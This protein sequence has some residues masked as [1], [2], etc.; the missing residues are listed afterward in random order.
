MTLSI[1]FISVAT[2]WTSGA[3]GWGADTG[4]VSSRRI[5]M[6]GSRVL[7][8]GEVRDPDRRSSILTPRPMPTL[9]LDD[10]DVVGMEVVSNWIPTMASVILRCLRA[11]PTSAAP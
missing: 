11:M 8:R 10:P 4:R 1:L 2:V 9:R 5:T 7:H 6:I 3:S